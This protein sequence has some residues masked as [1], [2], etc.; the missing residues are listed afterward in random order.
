MNLF[1]KI[2]MITSFT[3]EIFGR[4]LFIIS[5]QKESLKRAES[6]KKL[7]IKN[8]QI[9]EKIIKM[10][11]LNTP[12][13]RQQASLLHICISKNNKYRILNKNQDVL[14]RSFAHFTK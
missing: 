11:E 7:L 5:Y 10:K 12:C 8:H 4:D 14:H 6:V 3:S 2:L 1:F 13:I 9:P